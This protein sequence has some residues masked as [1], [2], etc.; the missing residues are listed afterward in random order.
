MELISNYIVD[1]LFHASTIQEAYDTAMDI[2]A[3]IKDLEQ[4]IQLLDQ[5][6]VSGQK[7]KAIILLHAIKESPVSH[8]RQEKT[9]LALTPKMW[10]EMAI[11]MKQ[12]L[13]QRPS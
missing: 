11:K 1:R 2:A 10:V 12:P 6:I 13:R 8:L 9:F 5:L 4:T 3:E 7:E